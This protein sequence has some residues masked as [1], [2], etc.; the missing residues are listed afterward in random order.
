[1]KALSRLMEDRQSLRLP[2]DMERPV[3]KEDLSKIL[4]AGRWAPTAHNMQN[5]EIVVIDDRA[6]LDA[7]S[8]I[9]RPL[10]EAFIREN[11]GQLSFSDDELRARKVGIP[12]SVFPPSW[13]DPH[14]TLTDHDEEELASMQRP[15]PAGPVFLIV[16]YDPARRA[17]ASEGDFLGIVSLGCVM[18][19]MWLMAHSL[20]ISVHIISSLGADTV[21]EE[22]KSILQIPGKLKVAYALRLGYPVLPP[23]E[24]LRVRRD[25]V[26]FT[27]HDRYGMKLPQ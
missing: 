9:K 20:A 23:P 17:P 7:L 19:N 3:A 24:Y 27:H 16:L 2:F 6:L 14:F 8:A 10:S 4:E 5:F 26:D 15:M 21:E 18:Q 12:A 1:M 22:V 11:Y 13:R 25:I